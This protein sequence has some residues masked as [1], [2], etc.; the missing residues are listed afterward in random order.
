[1]YLQA[2]AASWKNE[3]H[4][5]Q[6]SAT[7]ESL[8]FPV[9]GDR[10]VSA[11]TTA[12]VLR[13][14]QPHWTRVPET[15]S[16]LRGR[17]E[18]VLDFARAKGWRQGENAARWKGGLQGLLP[19]V[20]RVA[21]TTHQPAL[22]WRQLPAFVTALHEV[23]GVAA[24]A[25]EFAI[26]CAARSG[27]V[28]GMTWGEVDMAEAL[29]VIPG[30]R[31][32][33]GRQHRV[34]LSEPALAILRAMHPAPNVPT[35][36]PRLRDELVFP[37]QRR[38]EPLSDMS[39]SAVVRRMNGESDPPTWRD[40][41]NRAVVPHGMRSSFRDWAAES[42]GVAREVAESA[43]AHVLRDAVEAAYARSDLLER[44]RPLMAAWARHVAGTKGE[45]VP[46]AARSA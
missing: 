32:K 13:V 2:H 14:L 41:E 26:L 35:S 4:R 7:L 30:S 15:A 22:P 9:I 28:R 40:A 29:W 37:G 18:A 12:D 21:R 39:I 24:R 43:L 42:A 38:G 16:R 27:E 46:F 31:M 6:W 11:I 23:P 5:A 25:L 44:R 8:A 10:P 17:I 36:D 19:A 20:S 1:L 3:K 34:P 33:S 45:V